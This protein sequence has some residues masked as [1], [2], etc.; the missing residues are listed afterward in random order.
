MNTL[1][2]IILLLLILMLNTG[3]VSNSIF[4]SSFNPGME[5][6]EEDVYPDVLKYRDVNRPIYYDF[7]PEIKPM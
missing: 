1:I 7:V 2:I 6:H 4:L 5:L 3:F